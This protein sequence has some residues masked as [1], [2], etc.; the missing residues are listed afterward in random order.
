[1]ISGGTPAI[2]DVDTTVGAGVLELE[3][4]SIEPLLLGDER[5]EW[6]AP[7]DGAELMIAESSRGWALRMRLASGSEPWKTF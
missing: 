3:F 1:M 5:M 7:M 4:G 2:A 6:A